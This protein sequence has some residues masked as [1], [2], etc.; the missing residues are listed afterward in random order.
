MIIPSLFR[1]L[2]PFGQS[3]SRLTP[4]GIAC[5]A[6]EGIK[7]KVEFYLKFLNKHKNT[8]TKTFLLFLSSIS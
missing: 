2:S 6:E 1:S 3:L 5:L 8:S 4:S 7:D